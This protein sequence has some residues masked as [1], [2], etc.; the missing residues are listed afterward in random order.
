M[1]LLLYFSITP[2][3]MTT[4]AIFI[5]SSMSQ[6]RFLQLHVWT[7][8]ILGALWIKNEGGGVNMQMGMCIILRI[9]K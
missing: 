1:V 7:F 2:D 4:C 3:V 9:L 6:S 8:T 5:A